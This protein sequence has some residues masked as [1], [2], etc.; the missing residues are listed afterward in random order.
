M[1]LEALGNASV[2]QHS[3]GLLVST[4]PLVT[5]GQNAKVCLDFQHQWK[6]RASCSNLLS[7]NSRFVCH[8]CLKGTLSIFLYYDK[9]IQECLW[10]HVG[11]LPSSHLLIWKQ[12]VLSINVPTKFWILSECILK[13]NSETPYQNHF[14][15]NIHVNMCQM[16]SWI[17]S[18]P[19]F[20]R[21]RCC[22]WW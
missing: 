7:A 11:K 6:Q 15:H 16:C 8:F 21:S 5:M 20:S 12:W 17:V 1:G 13:V 2:T 10:S 18:G 22:W 4:V 19:L 9:K 3:L 14:T